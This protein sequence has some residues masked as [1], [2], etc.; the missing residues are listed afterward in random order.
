ML[1][2]EDTRRTRYDF[3]N[4]FFVHLGEVP[5]LVQEVACLGTYAQNTATFGWNRYGYEYIHDINT[6][7]REMR[8]NATNTLEAKHLAYEFILL[9]AL[10]SVFIESDTDAINRNIVVDTTAVDPIQLNFKITG[11]I[12]RQIPLDSIPGLMRL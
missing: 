5:M 6:V 8:S 10:S 12:A 2:R 11:S 4:P 1:K 9:Q 7:T 3:L